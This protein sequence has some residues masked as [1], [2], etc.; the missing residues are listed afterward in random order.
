MTSRRH[1]NDEIT[2]VDERSDDGK[3]ERELNNGNDDVVDVVTSN[4]A[5]INITH[6]VDH[7]HNVDSHTVMPEVSYTLEL[8]R[9]LLTPSMFI[10]TTRAPLRTGT[11]FDNPPIAVSHIMCCS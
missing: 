2:H 9:R 7:T 4:N 3:E 1:S 10:N 8:M 6:N 11:R 5:A